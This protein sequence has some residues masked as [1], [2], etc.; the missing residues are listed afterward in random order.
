[1]KK[2][3]LVIGLGTF[4]YALATK[5]YQSGH[6][7]MTIEKD[8][9]L[10]NKIKDDVT[11]SI[12]ADVTD[13]LVLKEIDPTAF[14]IVIL[15]RSSNLELAVLTLVQLKNMK[16][17]YIIAKANSFLQRQI[18]LKLGADEVILAEEEMAKRVANRI[19]HPNIKDV[20]D[21]NTDISLMMVKVPKKLFG[22]TLKELDLRK[23]NNITVFM[24]KQGDKTELIN[25][26]DIKFEEGDELFVAGK[27][28]NIL[29]IF[30]RD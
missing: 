15:G 17:K 26:P 10:V 23:K 25:N 22:K 20:F 30:D 24:R 5:L 9:D 21:F 4:G 28:A 18:L 14:D 29:K 16:V 13:P 19:T 27:E 6:H 2:D 11:I 7:V 8:E 3:I 1:M 12:V